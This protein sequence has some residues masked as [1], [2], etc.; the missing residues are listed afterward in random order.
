[1]LKHKVIREGASW[2]KI[3]MVYDF[4][5]NTLLDILLI[6]ITKVKIFSIDS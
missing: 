5:M 1:M 4:M 3:M 6:G 2:T